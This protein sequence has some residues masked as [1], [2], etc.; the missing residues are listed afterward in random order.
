MLVHPLLQM[1]HS[2]AGM[3]YVCGVEARGYGNSEFSTQFC[4]VPKTALNID[5]I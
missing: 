3:L 5:S 1:Y 4:C 2:G